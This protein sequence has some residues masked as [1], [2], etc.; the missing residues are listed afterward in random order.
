ML[1][2]I[3]LAN[4][5]VDVIKEKELPWLAQFDTEIMANIAGSK[6]E[7]YVE[8]IRRLNDSPVVKAV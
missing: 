7:D 3:G 4:P 8:V 1:N 5:G 6:E 2:A